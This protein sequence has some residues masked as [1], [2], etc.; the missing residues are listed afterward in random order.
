MRKSVEDA[1]LLKL[2]Q[3]IENP[4]SHRRISNEA[5]KTFN[6]VSEELDNETVNNK[7]PHHPR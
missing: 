2:G 5:R 3:P 4:I 1:Y 6:M 7:I